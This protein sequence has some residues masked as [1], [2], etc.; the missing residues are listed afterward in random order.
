M[1][2]VYHIPMFYQNGSELL[3]T[4]KDD[5]EYDLIKRLHKLGVIY[6]I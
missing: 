6:N 1:K 2:I 4:F 3:A 5:F